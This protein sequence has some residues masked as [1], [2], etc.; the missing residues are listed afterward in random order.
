M[1]ILRCPWVRSTGGYCKEL[2]EY[3]DGADMCDLVDKWCLMEGGEP[4]EE[5]ANYLEEMR[6]EDDR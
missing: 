3:I 6:K 2:D 5:Y 4:C 1:N